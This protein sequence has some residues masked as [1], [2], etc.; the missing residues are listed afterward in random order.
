[1]VFD[2]DIRTGVCQICN[3]SVKEGEIRNTIL[4]HLQYEDTDP[5]AWTVE[6]CADCH[7]NIHHPDDTKIRLHYSEIKPSKKKIPKKKIKKE[8]AYSLQEIRK[9][10]PRA[11]EKWT[12]SNDEFLKKFWEHN[13]QRRKE[14]ILQLMQIFGR[15]RGAIVSRLNKLGLDEEQVHFLSQ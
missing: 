5:L 9:T 3:K 11:Y 10:Y 12:E 4:H 2:R 7:F 15:N 8:K 1:M 14:K 13:K 6:V